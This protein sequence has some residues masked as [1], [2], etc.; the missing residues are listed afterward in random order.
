MTMQQQD[1]RPLRTFVAATTEIMEERL[2]DLQLLLRIRPLVE[3]LIAEQNWLPEQFRR[4]SAQSVPNYLL[5]CDPL[6]RFSVIS[7]VLAAGQQSPIEEYPT[8]GI[9]GV[10][11]G[12]G[13]RRMYQYTNRRLIESGMERVYS[14]ATILWPQEPMTIQSIANTQSDGSYVSVGIFGG[15][16]GC[17]PHRRFDIETG[18]PEEVASGYVNSV[19]PNLWGTATPIDQAAI[20]QKNLH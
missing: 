13:T 20:S 12:G 10:L 17:L 16:I 8:W 19:I 1:L 9:V 3:F 7:T 6:Q 18:Q 4:E 2:Q 11:G 5:F 15:N 14:G